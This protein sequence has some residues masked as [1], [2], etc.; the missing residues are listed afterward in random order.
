MIS[1]FRNNCSKRIS[2]IKSKGL[3]GMMESDMDAFTGS[4]KS[5]I[6]D[7]KKM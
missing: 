6:E 1:S 7:Q 4:I 3:G 5:G 2:D